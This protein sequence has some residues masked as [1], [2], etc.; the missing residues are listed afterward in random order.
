MI[1][2]FI[3][4]FVIYPA[5]F[6]LTAVFRLTPIVTLPSSF[7]SAISNASGAVDSLNQFVPVFELFLI[8]IGFFLVYEIAYFGMKLVNWVIRKIP[9]IS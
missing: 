2:D 6:A 9:T 7:T 3:V 5:V 4:N 1:F 8:L